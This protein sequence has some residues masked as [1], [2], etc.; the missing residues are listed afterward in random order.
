M[1]KAMLRHLSRIIGREEELTG[2]VRAPGETWLCRCVTDVTATRVH[3]AVSG[4]QV[5]IPAHRTEAPIIH[6][7]L[8]LCAYGSVA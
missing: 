2:E 1:A 7:C 3:S 5:R 6:I 4:R 8:E